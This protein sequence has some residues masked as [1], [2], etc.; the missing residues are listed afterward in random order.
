MSIL[1]ISSLFIFLHCSSPQSNIYFKLPLLEN[2]AQLSLIEPPP[3]IISFTRVYI[4]GAND[5]I[6]EIT[7]DRLYIVYQITFKD[8]Y[9]KYSDFL[10]DALNQKVIV[11][12]QNPQNRLYFSNIFIKDLNIDNVYKKRGLQGIMD[13]YCVKKNGSYILNKDNLTMNKIMTVSYF[14]FLNQ[15]LRYDDD[16]YATIKFKEISKDLHYNEA[17]D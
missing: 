17:K 12:T 14:F 1:R 2:I 8:K 5:S 16:Y 6:G 10:F 9:Q 3:P 11:D 13:N 4:K 7:F 15:Y